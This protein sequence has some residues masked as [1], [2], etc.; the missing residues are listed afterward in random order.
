MYLEL[1]GRLDRIRYQVLSVMGSGVVET[2]TVEGEIL[3]AIMQKVHVGG[4]IDVGVV[5]VVGVPWLLSSF[6]MLL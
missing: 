2:G 1:I 6:M 3:E 5:R 4:F